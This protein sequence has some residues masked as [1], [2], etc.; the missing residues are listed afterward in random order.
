MEQEIWKEV[1][2]YNGIYSASTLGRIR[3]DMSASG[4]QIGR[5]LKPMTNEHGYKFVQFSYKSI[6]SN[7]RVHVIIGST[8]IGP[9]PY[10]FETNHKDGNKANCRLDNLEYLTKKEN[11]EHAKRIGLIPQGSMKIDSKLTEKEVYEIRKIF[12]PKK[13]NG[14][15]TFKLAIKFNVTASTIRDIIKRKTWNHI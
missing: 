11:N 3:R 14:F 2:G 6:V 5:I 13:H 15:N 8:F 9:R 1:P 12:V 4:T 10:K 7:H